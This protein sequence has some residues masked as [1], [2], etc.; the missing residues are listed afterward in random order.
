MNE[1]IKQLAK[2]AGYGF[3]IHLSQGGGVSEE[4]IWGGVMETRKIEKFTELI[5]QE[6]VSICNDTTHNG[7]LNAV[8]AGTKIKEHFGVE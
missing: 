1:K 7:Y 5:I 4:Y 2:Q 8:T 6:C 3:E